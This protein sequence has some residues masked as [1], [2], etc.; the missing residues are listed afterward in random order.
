MSGFPVGEGRPKLGWKGQSLN[1]VSQGFHR[2]LTINILK[3]GVFEN[4]WGVTSIIG[5][6]SG[7]VP[8]THYYSIVHKSITFCAEIFLWYSS[9]YFIRTVDALM[10]DKNGTRL[11][12]DMR[13]SRIFFLK[14]FHVPIFMMHICRIA[15]LKFVGLVS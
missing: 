6:R 14:Q 7:K 3:F 8:V 4:S 13:F 1:R 12:P 15:E 10:T 11:V 2:F 9:L 5:R